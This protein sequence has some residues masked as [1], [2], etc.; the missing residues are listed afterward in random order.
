MQVSNPPPAPLTPNHPHPA[1]CAACNPRRLQPA[2]PIT[3]AAC[4][5]RPV[6][7]V[8]CASRT[9]LPRA[10]THSPSHELTVHSARADLLPPDLLPRN[11]FVCIAKWDKWEI[12]IGFLRLKYQNTQ[13]EMLI[14]N[15]LRNI[16]Q[17]LKEAYF[18]HTL[19][20]GLT[21][22]LRRK[23]YCSLKYNKA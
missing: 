17:H 3:R 1:I 19:N 23:R 9:H 13:R 2:P 20:H 21:L 22:A 15:L 5:P 12:L 11:A 7:P 18:S 6:H 8:P 10:L 14:M 4:N 16:W